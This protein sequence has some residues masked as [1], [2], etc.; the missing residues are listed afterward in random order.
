M[1]SRVPAD[2]DYDKRFKIKCL[3]VFNNLQTMVI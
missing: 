3:I 1:H 2:D